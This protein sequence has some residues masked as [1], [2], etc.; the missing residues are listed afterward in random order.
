MKDLFIWCLVFVLVV[1]TRYFD[2]HIEVQLH[3]KFLTC[4]F[5]SFGASGSEAGEGAGGRGFSLTDLFK[6]NFPVNFEVD[7]NQTIPD[8]PN[9]ENARKVDLNQTVLDSPN[10]GESTRASI[11]ESY[12]PL[13]ED[14]EELRKVNDRLSFYTFRCPLYEYLL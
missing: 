4:V 14:E 5:S 11:T 2:I 9:L 3:C 1:F 6:N 7:L 13:Q 10:L 8:S 12:H